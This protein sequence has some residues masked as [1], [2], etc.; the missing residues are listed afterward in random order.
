MAAETASF[1]TNEKTCSIPYANIA[2][3]RIPMSRR[4]TVSISRLSVSVAANFKS[5]DSMDIAVSFR[6]PSDKMD[7]ETSLVP[8]SCGKAVAELIAVACIVLC[9]W[10][11]AGFSRS[12]AIDHPLPCTNR[13]PAPGFRVSEK[14]SKIFTRRAAVQSEQQRETCITQRPW[15]NAVR[16]IGFRNADCGIAARVG[17]T[18]LDKLTRT[19]INNLVIGDIGETQNINSMTGRKPVNPEP[20]TANP[21]QC[22]RP[23]NGERRTVNGERCA[24]L[25]FPPDNCQIS[26]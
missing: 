14:I 20:R 8:E 3:P 1:C 5:R 23:A 24:L 6:R 26:L 2:S 13:F 7:D 11:A 17:P 16:N 10:F 25:A 9:G 18:G 19:V 22:L 12:L 4:R 21:E 15:R